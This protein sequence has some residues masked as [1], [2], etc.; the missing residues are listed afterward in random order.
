M[1][2]T[3]TVFS[4]Q[5]CGMQSIKWLG[6]C[7]ECSSWNSFEE[8]TYSSV[9][10]PDQVKARDIV[11]LQPP[12]LLS[13][14]DIKQD[15]RLVIGIGELDRVLGSGIVLGSVVLIGGDPGIGKSTLSLQLCS[16][17]V[18]N[19][20]KV[21]YVSGEESVKQLKLRAERLNIK[22]QENFYVVNQTNVSIIKEHIDKLL[23]E[24]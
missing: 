14:I 8:E 6:R 15:S 20:H 2:K 5:K 19:K 4:C 1:M 21:L 18:K 7:P 23:P 10:A 24:V 13:E 11:S 16:N 9:Q 12:M 22:D 17:L 3:K